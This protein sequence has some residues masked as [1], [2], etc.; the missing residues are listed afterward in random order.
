MGGKQ[1]ADNLPGVQF[2]FEIPN[3]FVCDEPTERIHGSIEIRYLGVFIVRSFRFKCCIDQ[4]K[5]SFYR[6][7][8]CIFAIFGRLALE[9]VI[10]Q[11][12][13]QKCLPVFFILSRGV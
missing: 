3:S 11:L 4:A 10:L 8:N 13:K 5:R 9:E 12:M 7:A 1:L 6:A 2:V